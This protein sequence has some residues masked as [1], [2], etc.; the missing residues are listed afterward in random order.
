MPN[1]DLI[2]NEKEE[3]G[4][5]DEYSPDVEPTTEAPKSMWD[6]YSELK[7]EKQ[8]ESFVPPAAKSA[9]QAVVLFAFAGSKQILLLLEAHSHLCVCPDLCLM[10]FKTLVERNG[11]VSPG[12]GNVQDGLI[13]TMQALR[14]CKISKDA[15][16]LFGSVTQAYRALQEWCAPRILV[17]GTEAYSAVPE[18]SF[19]ESRNAFLDP[20]FVHLLR[21]PRECLGDAQGSCD[22]VK[23]EKQWLKFTKFMLEFKEVNVFEARCEDLKW[24]VG[25]IFSRLKIPPHDL[26]L[27][28]SMREAERIY[29][30][31]L[32][33]DTHAV[34][35]RLGYTLSRDDR[36]TF[37][38][39]NPKAKQGV[40][41]W[42]REGDLSKPVVVFVN[43]IS[44]L[45]GGGELQSELPD[46]VAII[47][48]Q[49]PDLTKNFSVKS[50]TERAAYY[51][52]ILVSELHGRYQGMLLIGYS[53]GG[54]LAFEM[55]L[56]AKTISFECKL[57]LIDPS[58]YCRC[59]NNNAESYL[60]LRAKNYDLFFGFLL[61]TQ[62][63][64]QQ[65]VSLNDISS[66]GQLEQYVFSAA[67][68]EQLACELSRIVDTAVK[69]YMEISTTWDISPHHKY[70]GPC[71]FLK[72]DPDYFIKSIGYN[73][74]DVHHPDG[75]YGWTLP[76]SPGMEA[77]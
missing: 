63:S 18:R 42:R 43:G 44:G 3:T 39:I 23:L 49:A 58:P 17:D 72:A 62:T 30:G 64:F 37:R 55:A 35:W 52:Q 73:E 76:L 7:L 77:I 61:R 25:T 1:G 21:N 50:T 20:H 24:N 31:P 12:N 29:A 41:V 27:D 54:P 19:I 22:I 16:D 9:R 34:A 70:T 4:L 48:I 36:S 26:V 56:Q 46:D 74:D 28:I 59:S 6:I 14:N 2:A 45:A 15:T 47:S 67:P 38:F 5:P 60:M 53:G 68:S 33:S 13:H 75:V 11:A 71:A 40:V 66:V 65:A 8:L 32:Q 51:L 10:P 57:C 69:Q